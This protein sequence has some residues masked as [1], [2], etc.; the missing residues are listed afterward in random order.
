MQNKRS[1]EFILELT[2]E[3]KCNNLIYTFLR[4]DDLSNL[5]DGDDID[6]VVHE[7]QKNLNHSIIMSIAKKNNYVIYKNFEFNDNVVYTIFMYIDN[8]ISVLYLHFQFNLRLNQI[9]IS[10]ENHLYLKNSIIFNN[11]CVKNQ[12]PVLDNNYYVYALITHAIFDK[13]H[14]KDE[15]KNKLTFLIKDI[16]KH[17]IKN[18]F[19][20]NFP[21]KIDSAF[22]ELMFNLKFDEIIQNKKILF[23]FKICFKSS[24]YYLLNNLRRTKKYINKIFKNNG[25]FIVVLGPDGSGKTTIV[26][27]L[28]NNNSYKRKK[29]IYF[30]SSKR[31][32]FI[33]LI[34]SKK[35][36]RGKN[37][38]SYSQLKEENCTSY[39]K[40]AYAYLRTIYHFLKFVINYV[41]HIY[42]LLMKDNIIMGDRYFYDLLIM[43]DIELSNNFKKIFFFLTP[44][45]DV[46]ILL[47]NDPDIIYSRKQEL[48]IDEISRQLNSYS[49][50][51]VLD[52]KN[53][54][55]K[56]E[57]ASLKN[58]TNKINDLLWLLIKR[59]YT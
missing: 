7:N 8:V 18:I 42:P 26:N 50:L 4:D 31:D 58:T 55:Q 25:L 29:K 49:D 46:S 3:Y 11:V 19:N 32:R 6:I 28:F 54:F 16:D 22:F 24:F 10:H 34:S 35:N 53:K 21:G 41:F 23:N 59:K 48:S 15:Y 38:N 30:G 2:K 27:E 40:I 47:N 56:I 20:E 14:F 13:G 51:K 5:V 52:N 12:F 9:K 17:K 33:N 39:K 1:Y 36:L 37:F 57:N 43:R 44:S 45:P